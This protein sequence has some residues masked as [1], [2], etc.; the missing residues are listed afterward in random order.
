MTGVFVCI[1]LLSE[2]DCGMFSDVL[3]RSL[4]RTLH[5]LKQIFLVSGIRWKIWSDTSSV[6][7]GDTDIFPL[8]ASE[9]IGFGF[10]RRLPEN[11]DDA[12][13]G[14]RKYMRC[15]EQTDEMKIAIPSFP[16]D[17]SCRLLASPKHT[18]KEKK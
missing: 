17:L 12:R 15:F 6:R 14:V 4:T 7:T 8:C 2:D 5:G 16:L 9:P 3:T 13:L 10:Q 18:Q 1:M 11:K